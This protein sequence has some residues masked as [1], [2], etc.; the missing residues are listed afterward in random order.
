MIID[1]FM[2]HIN[3]PSPIFWCYACGDREEIL[4]L[5]AKLTHELG[6][7]ATES[8]ISQIKKW[9]GGSA[10]EFIELYR[11]LNGFTLYI[12]TNGY[13][14]GITF[15]PVDRWLAQTKEMKKQFKDMGFRQNEL[16]SSTIDTLAFAEIPHSGNY[17]TIK[18]NGAASGKIFYADHDD[19]VE[20]P[21][22]DS[23]SNLLSSIL[24]DPA[25]F[26]N[27]VGCY[28]RYSDGNTRTQWIPKEYVGN[29][30]TN[31]HLSKPW[32]KFW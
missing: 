25:K 4:S 32:W 11:R 6:E 24:I 27:S 1:T 18:R 14:A 3:D 26:L 17:F 20:E 13:A 7:P 31:N 2:E 21:L 22:Y 29:F 5:P 16:P 12:D 10:N 15:Y 8:D 9:F 23:L 28:T 19:C 30:S